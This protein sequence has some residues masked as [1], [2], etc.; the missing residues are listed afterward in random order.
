MDLENIT[1]NKV[2]QGSKCFLSPMW[3]LA[4][5]YYRHLCEWVGI[6]VATGPRTIKKQGMGKERWKATEYMSY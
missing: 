5:G 6:N 4:S 2:T 3:I 1:L